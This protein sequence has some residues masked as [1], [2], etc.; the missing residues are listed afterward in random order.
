MQLFFS[1][2]EKARQFNAKRV[3]SGVPSRVVDNLRLSVDNANKAATAPSNRRFGVSL[4][5]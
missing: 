1:T 4:K 2:R 3:A 5:G